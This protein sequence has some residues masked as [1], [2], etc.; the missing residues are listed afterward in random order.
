MYNSSWF[1][2]IESINILTEAKG[3]FWIGSRFSDEVKGYIW[4]DGSYNSYNNW[5]NEEGKPGN[6]QKLF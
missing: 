2:I 6:F 5:D 3:N 4:V 1:A